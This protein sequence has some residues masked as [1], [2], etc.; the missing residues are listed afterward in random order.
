[1]VAHENT[2]SFGEDLPPR[3]VPKIR[4]RPISLAFIKPSSAPKFAWSR[5]SAPLGI[6]L[7]NAFPNPRHATPS[8]III[9]K[10]ST[11][12]RTTKKTLL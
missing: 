12:V 6:F 11:F 8:I 7:L 4:Q 2:K 5:P 9:T 3:R 10:R 1:M